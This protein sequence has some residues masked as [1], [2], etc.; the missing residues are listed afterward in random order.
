[1]V[2][3]KVHNAIMYNPEKVSAD[4]IRDYIYTGSVTITL[5]QF[6]GACCRALGLYDLLDY[7]SGVFHFDKSKITIVTNNVEERHDEYTIKIQDDL[8]WLKINCNNTNSPEIKNL[9][10]KY[11]SQTNK[12]Y[13]NLITF[14]CSFTGG[15]HLGEEGSWGYVLSNLLGCYHVNKW[16]GGSNTNINLVPQG[17]GTVDV[18]SKRITSVAEPTQATDAATKNYVDAVK[19]GLDVKDSVRVATTAN[20]TATYSNGTSGV[21]ATLT[22]S[23]TQAAITIDSIVLVSGDRV[24]VKDQASALQNG[25]YTVTTVGTAS[26][27]WVLT[28]A[29][30]A[31]T[32]VANSTTA[33]CKGSY[34]FV[35]AGATGPGTGLAANCP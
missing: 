17:T 21:G 23:G 25:I 6:E 8:A 31:D 24:L 28:R 4:V 22:N 11:V 18:G 33:L 34:F 2:N 35:S 15:H 7:V 16:G 27:N 29:T 26:T 19:T 32:F 9:I 13:D 10:E 5:N 12:K 3:I 20:L 14:G 1:M 30:D